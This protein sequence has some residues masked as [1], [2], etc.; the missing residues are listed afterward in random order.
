MLKP[1]DAGLEQRLEMMELLAKEPQSSE[2]DHSD[3]IAVAAIDEP[4]FV[5][6]ARQLREFLLAKIRNIIKPSTGDGERGDSAI[7]MPSLRLHCIVD[8]DTTVQMF[9][10][11][12]YTSQVAMGSSLKPFLIL[13]AI[14]VSSYAPDGV[15][16]MVHRRRTGIR[17]NESPRRTQRSGGTSRLEESYSSICRGISKRSVR[18]K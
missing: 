16:K 15:W 12:F 10:R 11:R 6:K 8:F 2:V 9:S 13:W 17:R 14:I 18:P 5:G 4:T 1:G 7:P 3:N